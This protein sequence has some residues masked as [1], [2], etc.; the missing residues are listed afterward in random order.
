[1]SLLTESLSLKKSTTKKLFF[2]SLFTCCETGMAQEFYFPFYSSLLSLFFVICTRQIYTLF[3]FLFSFLC[4]AF[5]IFHIHV[6]C[7]AARYGVVFAMRQIFISLTVC[8][9]INYKILFIHVMQMWKIIVG[10]FT[11]VVVIYWLIQVYCKCVVMAFTR[12]NTLTN[13]GEFE[14]CTVNWLTVEWW[15]GIEMNTTLPITNTCRLK[16]LFV[17]LFPVRSNFPLTFDLQN[18]KAIF[19]AKMQGNKFQVFPFQFS[20]RY[21][22]FPSTE[23]TCLIQWKGA[24]W[25]LIALTAQGYIYYIL[26][27]INIFGCFCL[28]VS[29]WLVIACFESFKLNVRFWFV[30]VRTWI[31]AVFV[32]S[33]SKNEK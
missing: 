22:Y 10:R 18:R 2:H 19:F 32:D 26:Y 20:S 16:I 24:T 27:N 29:L 31:P 21:L 3:S 13:N 33:F 17:F 14:G 11:F 7:G 12:S 28:K 30:T 15:V 6:P 9:A 23:K 25:T 8:K 4:F 1:M 5:E